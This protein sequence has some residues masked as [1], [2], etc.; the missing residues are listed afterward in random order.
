MS[1]NEIKKGCNQYVLMLKESALL[2]YG[3]TKEGLNEISESDVL[4][5]GFQKHMG[6]QAIVTPLLLD[7]TINDSNTGEGYIPAK[8]YVVL[9]RENPDNQ[10]VEVWMREDSLDTSRK[11]IG[12]E[13]FVAIR[14]MDFSVDSNQAMVVRSLLGSSVNGLN[15]ELS[16]NGG[17][18]EQFITGGGGIS[19]IYGGFLRSNWEIVEAR[20]VAILIIIGMNG[21]IGITNNVEG[22]VGEW[23]AVGDLID[24]N[25]PAM[26]NLWS[27]IVVD[28]FTRLEQEHLS[29]LQQQVE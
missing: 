2:E 12:R 29:P 3:I 21:E 10:M 20:K 9:T 26:L 16:F 13:S 27:T 24:K 22:E 23:V 25:H 8:S 1:S 15:K 17:S 28:Y 11:E 6:E 7:L 18:F 5:D 14:D 4:L 19:I